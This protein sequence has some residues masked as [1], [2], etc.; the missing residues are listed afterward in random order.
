MAD[1]EYSVRIATEARRFHLDQ[2]TGIELPRETKGMIIPDPA[3]RKKRTGEGWTDGNTANVAIGQGDV[4]V[5]PLSMACFVAS[6]ARGD[7]ARTHEDHQ[8]RVDS[9]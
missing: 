4:L 5:T 2:P 3:W 1:Q 6:L 8:G 9:E 7:L